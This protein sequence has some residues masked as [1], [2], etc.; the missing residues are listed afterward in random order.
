MDPAIWHAEAYVRMY[1]AVKGKESSI[2]CFAF[3]PTTPPRNRMYTRYTKY[4][5]DGN[6]DVRVVS[7][8]RKTTYTRSGNGDGGHFG[9]YGGND[10][11]CSPVGY[12]PGDFGPSSIGGNS[13]T[14]FG[15]VG[16]E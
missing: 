3:P 13:A 4:T 6:I 8:S 5:K 15:G 12:A 1:E 11:C 7:G 10:R 9:G 14:G 16:I 2:H